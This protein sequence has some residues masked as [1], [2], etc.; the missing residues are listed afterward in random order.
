MEYSAT[1]EKFTTFKITKEEKIIGELHYKNWFKFNAEIEILNSKYQVEQKGF[2][3]TTLELL[4]DKK[5]L[6]KFA[7][8]W[9]GNIVLNTFFDDVEK[10]YT[11]SHKGFF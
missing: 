6:L 9:D 5:V 8:N 10:N 3:G 4:N 11:F 7:M 1:S 2:W